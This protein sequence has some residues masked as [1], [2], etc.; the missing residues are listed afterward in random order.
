M[1]CHHRHHPHL[2]Q[3][4]SCD[5]LCVVL[6]QRVQQYERGK[7]EGALVL[8]QEPAQH[9]PSVSVRI[10]ITYEIYNSLKYGGPVYLCSL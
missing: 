10:I 5:G 3:H 9:L 6:E 4:H 2:L 7:L 1:A 8:A